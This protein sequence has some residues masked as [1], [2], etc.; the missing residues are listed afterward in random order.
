MAI[1]EAKYTYACPI[2]ASPDTGIEYPARPPTTHTAMQTGQSRMAGDISRM[3]GDISR[4]AGDVSQME[5]G[6]VTDG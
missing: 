4:M 5:G 1:H 2:H 3:A 6:R